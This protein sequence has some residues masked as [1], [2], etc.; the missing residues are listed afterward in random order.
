LLAP[1]TIQFGRAGA[2]ALPPPAPATGTAVEV[3]R[4]AGPGD[5]KPDRELEGPAD[6]LTLDQAVSL[7]IANNL[8]LRAQFSEISQADADVL[9]ASLRTNPIVFTDAQQVP[10]GS[11]RT[12]GTAIQYDANIVHPLDLSHKRQARTRSA[13]I[14]RQVEEARYRDTVRLAIDAVYT[15][16]IDVLVAQVNYDRATGKISKRKDPLARIPVDEPAAALTDAQQ[17]LA[18]LLN[19]PPA[20]IVERQ[21]HGRLE[22]PKGE[23]M[24]PGAADLI[25]IALENRPDV[26]ARRLAVCLADSDVRAVMANRLDDILLLYQPY[27]FHDGRPAGMG[28]SLAWAL[29]VTVPMPIYNRQ[30]GNLQKARL[31]ADQARIQLAS[32]EQAVA[33]EVQSAV[34]EHQATH[35][36]S[37]RTFNDVLKLV[38]SSLVEVTRTE[39][40]NVPD[41]LKKKIAQ[42]EARLN[43]LREDAGFDKLKKYYDALVR[44][45]RSM[46]HL[47][48][49]TGVHIMD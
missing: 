29:G 22:F 35:L 47:N 31:I 28:N 15:A 5:E 13:M 49:V 20:L 38:R 40:L 37:E 4:R 19:I 36:A 30:Q 9:T 16:Y 33:S 23:P 24:V 44:H 42:M 39:D 27:T 25:R 10:Y 2:E 11:Y 7:L 48:T 18:V 17:K 26:H 41:D 8:E 1:P 46:L 43:D 45:R 12:A 32:F 34:L 14:G 21:L 6:G 3:R